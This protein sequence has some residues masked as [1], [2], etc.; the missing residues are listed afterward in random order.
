[1]RLSS[2]WEK[3]IS[4]FGKRPAVKRFKRALIWV[5][6]VRAALL[7]ILIVAWC[8]SLLISERAVSVQQFAV[9]PNGRTMQIKAGSDKPRQWSVGGRPTTVRT[10]RKSV[11]SGYG[12]LLIELVRLDQTPPTVHYLG[13]VTGPDPTFT[14]FTGYQSAWTRFPS[15]AWSFADTVIP[16]PGASTSAVHFLSAS[17]QRSVQR[18]PKDAADVTVIILPYWIPCCLLILPSIVKRRLH[19]PRMPGRC[20]NCNYDLR[21]TPDRCPECGHPIPATNTTAPTAPPAAPK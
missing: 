19:R 3:T 4:S 2:L 20:P 13:T 11:A 8:R 10:S 17:Y 1:M 12:R 18:P 7:S 16:P 14:R 6:R 5:R 9:W 15:T 21:A